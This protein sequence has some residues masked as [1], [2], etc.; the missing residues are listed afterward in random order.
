MIVL[1]ITEV[2]PA[3][4]GTFGNREGKRVMSEL[5]EN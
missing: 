3:C 2:V 4:G 1:A 5:G